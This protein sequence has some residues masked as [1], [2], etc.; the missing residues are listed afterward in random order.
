MNKV[1][2]GAGASLSNV[3]A[4]GDSIEI[5]MVFKNQDNITKA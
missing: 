4:R 2:M 5:K 3:T 1:S